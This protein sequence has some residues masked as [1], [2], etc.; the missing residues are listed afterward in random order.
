MEN[1]MTQMFDV[2]EETSE[3][4]SA[5]IQKVLN[6]RRITQPATLASVRNEI[7]K[8]IKTETIPLNRFADDQVQELRDEIEYLIEQHGDDSLAEHFMKP[9]ASQALTAL[10]DAC[11]DSF[12]ETSLAQVFEEMER[13]LLAQL[14]AQGELDVDD[15]QTVIAELQS[16]IDHHGPDAIAE[17]LARNP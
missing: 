7:R 10:I 13:G 11:V 12:G 14:I 4:L 6:D 9:R 15:E 2:Y 5:V 17:E 1:I 3:A 8:G 16:M